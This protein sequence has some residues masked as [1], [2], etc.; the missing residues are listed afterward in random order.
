MA[1]NRKKFALT[2]LLY[3]GELW[4]EVSLLPDGLALQKLEDKKSGY[5]FMHDSDCEISVPL[6]KNFV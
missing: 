4:V 1:E 2:H 3:A 6:L 5:C